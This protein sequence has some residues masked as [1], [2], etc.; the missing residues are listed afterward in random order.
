MVDFFTSLTK[1]LHASELKKGFDFILEATYDGHENEFTNPK[2]NLYSLL[3]LDEKNI[4]NATRIEGYKK[5]DIRPRDF[6][7]ILK[8]FPD[9]IVV[10][11]VAAV[12]YL[13]T[14]GYAL[15]HEVKGL[16][17]AIVDQIT[18]NTLE[19]EAVSENDAVI[20]SPALWKGKTPE[21]VLES[22][23]EANYSEPVIAFVLH[24][25]C[26]LTKTRVGSLLGP[27]GGQEES[28]CLR[29]ANRLLAE[30][31]KLTITKA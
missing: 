31:D 28:V 3:T 20:V 19:I 16:S 27:I 21:T 14:C 5:T 1:I 2:D 17:R 22:L 12:H 8:M 11:K 15:N 23:Q 6:A 26:G 24:N 25:W 30:A 4:A 18:A 10:A 7:F 29:R 9:T 13:H